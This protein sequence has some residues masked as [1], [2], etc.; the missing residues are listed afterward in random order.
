MNLETIETLRDKNILVTGGNGFLGSHV[1]SKLNDLNVKNVFTISSKDHDLCEW[2]A[3]DN[4]FICH[5]PDIVI[6]CAA[7]VG[8]IEFNKNHPGKIF[9][10]NTSMN[11]NIIESCRSFN[12]EKFIGIGSVCEYPKITLV[13][14]KEENLFDGEPEE[15]NGAYGQS[16]RMMLI[17][18]QAYQKEFEL[19]CSHLLMVNL[20]GPRDN[21]RDES[22]HVIPALIKR[23]SKARDNKDTEVTAWGDG[24]P[25]REF[26]YVEDAADAIIKAAALCDTSDPINIG[27]GEE[28]SIKTLT[29]TIA[30]EI[31]YNGKIIWDKTKPNG[32]PRR[33]LDVSKAKEYFGFEAKTK[34][35]DGIKKTIKWYEENKNG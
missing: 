11:L 7:L 16:K 21:F 4:V 23:F 8:G 2:E 25:T 15:T 5:K 26:L 14:F 28:I 1:L 3:C 29:E 27:N 33:C 20:Y 18:G 35:K 12:V 9:Y 17:Q 22:S 24:S 13:P 32:Q 30:E 10:R 6:H 31:G 34:F 19:N